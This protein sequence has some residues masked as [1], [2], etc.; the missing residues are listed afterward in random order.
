MKNILGSHGSYKDNISR[1]ECIFS[2]V[3]L[4]I[5]LLLALLC[6]CSSGEVNDGIIDTW[7][8][9]PSLI[10]NESINSEHA[11]VIVSYLDQTKLQQIHQYSKNEDLFPLHSIFLSQPD[12]LRQH[13]I[14]ALFGACVIIIL[15]IACIIQVL[16]GKRELISSKQKLEEA[17]EKLLQKSDLVQ[18]KNSELIAAEYKFHSEYTALL[19]NKEK[20]KESEAKYQQILEELIDVYYIVDKQYVILFASKNIVSMLG[21]D[22]IDD[23]LGHHVYEFMPDPWEEVYTII[24]GIKY[25]IV[26]D[27]PLRFQ[28]R[29]GIVLDC[30]VSG[31]PLYENGIYAGREG[32]V[33]DIS[34]EKAAQDEIS[35][36]HKILTSFKETANDGMLIVD[37]NRQVIVWNQKY[38]DLFDMPQDIIERNDEKETISY[39]L[40]KFDHP[41]QYSAQIE[42]IYERYLTN[43]RDEITFIDGT[44][45]ER[46]TTPIFDSDNEYIGRLWEFVDITE[47]V[48]REERL[49]QQFSLLQEQEIALK[50]SEEQYRRVLEELL[51]IYYFVDEHFVI[52]LASKSIV[53]IL[54]YDSLDD[55]LGHHLSEFVAGHW[56][57]VGPTYEETKYDFI[58]TR[59]MNLKKRD[60]SVLYCLASGKPV[61][62]DDVFVGREGVIKDITDLKKTQ[63]KLTRQNSVLLAVKEV[64]VGGLLV[65]DENQE[66]FLWNQR[67]ITEGGFRE[68]ELEKNR[69]FVDLIMSHN[70]SVYRDPE[71]AKKWFMDLIFGKTT[72][73][74]GE[75]AYLDGTICERYSAPIVGTDGTYYGRLWQFIN[76][77]ERVHREQELFSTKEELQKQYNTIVEGEKRLRESEYKYRSIINS[78]QDMYFR[79]DENFLITLVS[80]SLVTT[81]GYVHED[82]LLGKHERILMPC[83]DVY[84]A[85]LEAIETNTLVSNYPCTFM[86]TNGTKIYCL[87]ASHVLYDDANN[88]IGHEGIARDMSEEKEKEDTL[89]LKNSLLTALQEAYV[90]G[91]IV[92]DEHFV[93]LMFNAEFCEM[94]NLTQD[95]IS[96]GADGY[97]VYRHCLDK[98]H[99]SEIIMAVAHNIGKSRDK[100]LDYQFALLNGKTFHCYSSPIVGGDGTYYGRIWEF[101]DI[102]ESMYQSLELELAYTKILQK[103]SQLT[104]ALEGVGEGLWTWDTG[105]NH[106]NLNADFANQY[107]SLDAIQSIDSF[108]S[109]IHPDEQERC[110]KILHGFKQNI[111]GTRLEFEF[112]IQSTEGTWRFLIAR[113]TILDVNEIGLPL[114]VTGTFVDITERKQYEK[115]IREANRK[116]L[117]L[118]ETTRHD[119]LNQLNILFAMHDSL[120]DAISDPSIDYLLEVMDQALSTVHHQIEFTRDYQEI[121]ING[122]AWQDVNAY[123]T[124]A[125]TLLIHT[126]I[127]LLADSIPMIFADPLLEK[128]VYNI[129]ENSLRHGEYVT[130]MRIMFS[131]EDDNI[132]ILTFKDNGI[133]I[134]L[135]EKEEIFE[136]GFGKNTGLGLFLV[137]EIVGITGITIHECGA[138]GKGAEFK[139]TIPSG[140]WRW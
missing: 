11:F 46:Y 104:L 15:L 65:T 10:Q 116:M 42:E 38:L 29:D 87:I 36:Q 20:F 95:I 118:S 8:L 78:M 85:F 56:D 110:F 130:E 135:G 48:H 79:V 137:R 129:I 134:S 44:V 139:I 40:K 86:C 24:E 119:I 27:F 13:Y 67:F 28:R 83:F 3:H 54:G 5:F 72:F 115:S 93:V 97:G 126:P 32:I 107:R 94:W 9:P 30:L 108:I 55:F 69:G 66:L 17:Y 26:R 103:E 41:E 96:V 35:R 138:N 2:Y 60:G 47:R 58:T 37:E 81:L 82:D 50:K 109:A 74:Y 49:R 34:A 90:H 7:H 51:D 52:Q 25:E 140:S 122:A 68:E 73:G 99:N 113:G 18:E 33:R 128:A 106:I 75:E 39:A 61:Y 53:T 31:K 100:Q 6:G 84:K 59:P 16:R 133:G 124:G 111:S 89:R 105:I 91:I 76:I 112:Q 132:G 98:V 136:K 77:T 117:I 101:R 123:I 4:C 127:L 45:L 62:I 22:S 121:G 120:S 21:Y 43:Y 102:T 57:E 70:F 88:V 63:D 125:K 1:R 71:G 114:L 23:F 92:V 19:E 12:A 80:Q 14:V 64:L 131:V